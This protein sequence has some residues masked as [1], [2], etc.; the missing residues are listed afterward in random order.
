MRDTHTHTHTHTHTQTME[1][2]SAIKK[3]GIMPFATTWM[4]IVIIKVSE[5]RERQTSNDIT[6]V[7]LKYDTDELYKTD[8]QTQEQT[9]GC[10][11]VGEAGKNFPGSLGW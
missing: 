10:Q 6:Y 11:G 2:Y 7:D 1:Y 4:D 9:R 8:S 3:N 5:D